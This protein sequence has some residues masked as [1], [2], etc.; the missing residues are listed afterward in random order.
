MDRPID[1]TIPVCLLEGNVFVLP[2]QRGTFLR[3]SATKRYL[4]AHV[5]GY[6]SGL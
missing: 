6:A 3:L 5:V 2:F 1:D 4:I